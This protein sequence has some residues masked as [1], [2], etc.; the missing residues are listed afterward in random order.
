VAETTTPG[1]EWMAAHHDAAKALMRVVIDTFD[2]FDR[3]KHKPAAEW[4]VTTDE[5]F[6][7]VRAEVITRW[8]AITGLDECRF[9]FRDSDIKW[10]W[11][12]FRKATNPEEFRRWCFINSGGA[13]TPSIFDEFEETPEVGW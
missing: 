1:G 7:E 13:A 8:V 4:W 11:L 9:P 12:T 2:H 5:K 10:T 3:Q 6:A